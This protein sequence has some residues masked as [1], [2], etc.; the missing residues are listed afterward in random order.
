M[1]RTSFDYNNIG[2]DKD[3]EIKRNIIMKS[4]ISRI[5]LLSSSYIDNSIKNLSRPRFL[6]SLH[7][8]KETCGGNVN[9]VENLLKG[10]LELKINNAIRNSL[11]NPLTKILIFLTIILNLI[12]L[13]SI[14][15]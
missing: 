12:W 4:D 15:F 1:T 3:S 2:N 5:N 13:L 9:S 7:L 10:E 8:R 6:G 14:L 11:F